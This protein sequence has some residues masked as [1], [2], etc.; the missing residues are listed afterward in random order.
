MKAKRT[1]SSSQRPDVFN[2]T[3]KTKGL[4]LCTSGIFYPLARTSPSISMEEAPYGN[5]P[6]GDNKARM[7]S[8]KSMAC[9]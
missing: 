1:A 7:P 9:R 8:T 6:S 3:I 2:K 5:P 4:I